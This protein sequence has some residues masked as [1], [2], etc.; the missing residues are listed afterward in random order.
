M[1]SKTGL[2]DFLL[3]IGCEELPA[4]YM[5]DA[6]DW[7]ENSPLGLGVAAVAALLGSNVEWTELR[8]YGT[9]RRLVLHVRGVAPK[10]QKEEKGPP[11]QV[12]FDPSGKPT[13]ADEAFAQRHGLKVS[14]LVQRETS[15]GKALWAEYEIPVEKV[16][17]QVVPELIQ[18]I[19]FPKTMRW[20]KSGVRFARPIRWLLALYGAKLVSCSFGSLNSIAATYGT[21]RGDQ[22]RVSVRSSTD[23]FAVLKRL[24]I[25]L[26]TGV[27]FR[28][29][30]PD[31]SVPIEATYDKRNALLKQLEAAAKKAGGRLP[32]QATEEFDGLLNTA[33]FLAENPT[34]Q[35]GSFRTEYLELPA[36]VLATSMAKHL[37]LFSVFSPDGKKL[38]PK[39]LAVLEGKPG[40][41]KQVM[42]NY[43]RILEARFTDARFFWQEDMKARLEGRMPPLSMLTFHEKLGSVADRIPRLTALM[44]FMADRISVEDH[45]RASIQPAADLAKTDLVT[46]M[47]REY[48]SL[49]G[50]IGS[51]YAR[52]GGEGDAVV[53][54]LLEQYRPRTAGDPVPSTP[55]GAILSLADR[56]DTL[57]GYF[58]V[59]LKPTGSVDPYA[60]R[61][62]ALGIVRI[63]L[64]P[65]PGLSF[66]GLSIDSLF[67]QGIQSWGNRITTDPSKLKAEL[68]LFLRERFETL[69]FAVHRI[70]RPLIAAVLAVEGSDFAG[71]KERL[72][73]LRDWWTAAG[74]KRQKL[75]RAAKVA[76]RTGRIVRSVGSMDLP[77]EVDAG[78]LREP[79]EK[80]LWETWN[81]A[82]P[83]VRSSL[84]RRQYGQA[85]EAYSALYPVVHEFFEKV[86]VMDEDLNLRRNR[87]T[88]LRQI[89]QGL[90]GRFADLSDLPL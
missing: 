46:Q 45:V 52:L 53:G 39:F 14:Q 31:R 5:P 56:I 36:E 60:L 89:F 30:S 85:V 18:S 8:T 17:A 6:L 48:P 3:E 19:R 35:A 11:V 59:G 84:D 28:S 83:Q 67:E 65:P 82:A 80:E 1:K 25:Q 88:L 87:L 42:D 50:I 61:R 7:N 77:A 70:D 24:K 29:E 49:Q 15:R 20:D 71:A 63:L 66:V 44:N 32:D 23:Y 55:L 62:Q 57:A 21:R 69:S 33:T 79:I 43:D 64:E 54:A 38:L 81:R 37:K 16:L 22:K 41:P 86:F 73:L 9:P 12:A 74:S 10:V 51:H 47:V 34:V 2:R 90:A 40:R 13:R 27:G 4:D 76:E 75:E 58:G 26:E 72:D 68:V 78:T